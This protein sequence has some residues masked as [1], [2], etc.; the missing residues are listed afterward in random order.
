MPLRLRGGAFVLATV[1]VGLSVTNT[2]PAARQAAGL[3]ETIAGGGS[4]GDGLPAVRARLSLPGGLVVTEDGTIL[5]VDFGN[6]RIR[7]IDPKTRL[8]STIAGTGEAGFSGDGG[9]ASLATLARPENAT[10]D[11]QGNLVIVDEYNHRIRRVDRRTGII[12]TIAGSGRKG[13][14]G[15]GGSALD[16]AFDQPEG[17]AADTA[18]NLYIGDTQNNRIRRI[19]AATGVITTVAGSGEFGISPD[20]TPRLQVRFQRVARLAV[21]RRGHIYIADSPAH[22]I[23]VIDADTGRLRTFAG[24]GEEGFAGDGGPALAARLAY[25]EG[26]AID[27]R[28]D[29]YFCDIA[30]H[31]VRRV[32]AKTGVITTVAGSGE[33]GVSPDDRPALE[34]RLWSPG[35]LAFDRDGS[36]LIADVG[37]A[38]VLRVDRT[39]GRMRAIAGTGEIGD[40]GP[41]RQAILAVPGDVVAHADNLFIADYGNRRVR[42]VDLKSGR[43]TT[44]AG[45]G[46]ERRP[47]I[48]ATALELFLPEGLGLDA[49]G[50]VYIAD[51]LASRVWRVNAATGIVE[52]VAGSGESGYSGDGGPPE[53]AAL[54]LP[55]AVAVA[56]DGTVYISDYGNRCIRVVESGG[57]TIRTLE[58]ERGPLPEM[59]VVSLAVTADYLFWLVSGD[60]AVYRLDLRTRQ[61]ARVALPA[62]FAGPHSELADLIVVN[63]DL[64]I[65]DAFSH[66]VLRVAPETG[67]PTLVA[68]SG[69]QAFSGD[70]GSATEAALFQPGGVAVGKGG[71][72][73]IADTKNHRIR[74][75][76]QPTPGT[77]Q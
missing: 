57:M 72:V 54:R 65:A 50:N 37:S 12:S 29:V 46:T 62:I 25:P 14:G 26:V 30:S 39:T 23:L 1:L 16:A 5:V 35:R 60:R 33:K 11:A 71:D 4:V 34:S 61:P 67:A 2:V 27:A 38:R 66:R 43:I 28:G 52:L 22:K 55:G 44:F 19:D 59:P 17:I 31:R 40:G 20:G 69:I 74:R 10:L 49:R 36:L 53:R 75:V 77:R 7:R 76:F 21:D 13:F 3:I 42:R 47:G 63:K 8:I 15:D 58:A 45:G 56:D 6:H 41:A 24:T 70:G 32:S 68:G 9:P 51:N 73:F 64:L 18:G 48:R